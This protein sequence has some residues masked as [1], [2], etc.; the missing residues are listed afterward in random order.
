MSVVLC[1]DVGIKHLAF[2]CMKRLNNKFDILFWNVYNLIDD[3]SDKLC[4][5]EFKNGNKCNRKATMKY[6]SNFFCKTHSP[7]DSKKISLK[8]VNKLSYLEICKN[9]LNCLDDLFK[10]NEEMIKQIKIIGIELQMMKNPRMKFVSHCLLTKFCDFYQ[11]KNINV[12]IKFIRASRKLK[13]KYDGPEII[14][15][16]KNEYSKRKQCAIAYVEYFLQKLNI[17]ELWI[18]KFNNHSGKKCDL[19]EAMLYCMLLLKC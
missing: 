8:K 11:T 19:S 5:G 4:I 18:N 3:D 16:V 7:L 15:T 14:Y 12:D 9:I 6:E 1:I 10:N 13:I 17:N 2:C